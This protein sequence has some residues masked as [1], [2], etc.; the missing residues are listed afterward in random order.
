MFDGN[1]FQLLPKGRVNIDKR[2]DSMKPK[3]VLNNEK[4]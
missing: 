1:F 2:K 4:E 3:V